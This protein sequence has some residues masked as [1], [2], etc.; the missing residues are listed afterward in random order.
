MFLPSATGRCWLCL[1]CL[2]FN[3]LQVQPCLHHLSQVPSFYLYLSV[4][5]FVGICVCTTC[6]ILLL[7]CVQGPWFTTHEEKED[8]RR[9]EKVKSGKVQCHI[10]LIIMYLEINQTEVVMT[11][12]RKG[13]KLEIILSCSEQLNRRGHHPSLIKRDQNY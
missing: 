13:T 5:V 7:Q 11:F 9:R 6:H 1:L 12:I 4:F 8:G 10:H 3:I 2:P